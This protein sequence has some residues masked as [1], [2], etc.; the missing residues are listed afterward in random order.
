[1]TER[2]DYNHGHWPVAHQLFEKC[3]PVHARHL[4]I[5]R[6]YVRLESQNLVAG[7][8]GVRR[9]S[10]HLHVLLRGEGIGQQFADDG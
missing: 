1:L 2:A 8:E 7:H 3:Q 6:E 9:G 10:Y 5:Q 4:D